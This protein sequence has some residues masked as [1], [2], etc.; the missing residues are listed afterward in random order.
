ML[1]FDYCREKETAREKERRTQRKEKWTS[2]TWASRPF[3]EFSFSLFL[4]VVAF[5][6]YFWLTIFRLHFE[7]NMK[8]TSASFVF[9]IWFGSSSTFIVHFR[10]FAFLAIFLFL[11]LSLSLFLF[12]FVS[13]K[14]RKTFPS[15]LLF[16]NWNRKIK[17]NDGWKASEQ[18]SKLA[19]TCRF[20][21]YTYV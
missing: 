7:G 19:R 4:F 14:I 17:Q 6:Y 12:H 2:L 8:H 10:S 1:V 9:I 15:K 5:S 11:S 20:L 3:R 13:R 18:V 16:F 21:I